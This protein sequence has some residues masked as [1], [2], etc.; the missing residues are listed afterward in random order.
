MINP[1]SRSISLTIVWIVVATIIGC[2]KDKDQLSF[3]GTVKR[4]HVGPLSNV[5]VTAQHQEV[6]NGVFNSEYT[7]LGATQTDVS[8]QFEIPFNTATYTSLRLVFNKEGYHKKTLII[9]PQIF[10]ETDRVAKNVTLY[11]QSSITLHV[12]DGLDDFDQ[13]LVRYVD[14]SFDCVCCDAEWKYFDQPNIDTTLS[15]MVY[16]DQFVHYQYR[17]INTQID[18]LINDSVFCSPFENQSIELSY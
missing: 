17:L 1:S 3:G 18:T 7:S 15:C 9:D 14:A 4:A 6:V 12:L 16:G 10:E 5:Q 2:K 11:T 8:G 13:L